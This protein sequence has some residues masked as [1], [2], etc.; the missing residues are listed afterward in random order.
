MSL[1]CPDCGYPLPTN[2]GNASLRPARAFRIARNEPLASLGTS[3]SHNSERTFRIA[4]NEPFASLGTNLSHRSERAFR[5][6]RNESLASLGTSLSHRSERASRIAR[7]ESLASL[8][9]SLSHRSERAS[10]IARNEPLAS[11][12][13]GVA[14]RTGVPYSLERVGHT[15]QDEKVSFF[16]KGKCRLRPLCFI[17]EEEDTPSDWGFLSLPITLSLLPDCLR[18]IA[19]KNPKSDFMQYRSDQG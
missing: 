9:T 19:L 8:G 7:N 6:A 2:K 17:R 1:H 4:R 13:S 12:G 10:R 16:F 3:L 14:T 15:H 11:L 5:I 18:A